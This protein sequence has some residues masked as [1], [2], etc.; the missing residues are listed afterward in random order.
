MVKTY[1]VQM[2][3]DVQ[4]YAWSEV[5]IKELVKVPLKCCTSYH[6]KRGNSSKNLFIT[7]EL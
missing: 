6:S 2:V 5:F 1:C 4:I 7:P 3:I